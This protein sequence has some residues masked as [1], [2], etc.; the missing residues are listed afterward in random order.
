MPNP[1]KVT[2]DEVIQQLIAWKKNHPGDIPKRKHLPPHIRRGAKNRFGSWTNALHVAGF[3]VEPRQY[4]GIWQLEVIREALLIV[5]NEIGHSPTQNEFK[6]FYP[7]DAI[8]VAKLHYGGFNSVKESVGLPVYPQHGPRDWGWNNWHLSITAKILD[9]LDSNG[10]TSRGDFKKNGD[11]THNQLCTIGNLVRDGRVINA[12]PPYLHLYHLPGQEDSL[13]EEYRIF[14]V[15]QD[16]SGLTTISDK[17]RLFLHQNPSTFYEINYGLDLNQS[18]LSII[19]RLVNEDDNILKIGPR[20]H[21]LYYKRGQEKWLWP[22]LDSNHDIYKEEKILI[23]K[24][25]KRAPV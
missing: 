3:D 20:G 9:Y 6:D 13:P 5:A 25:L 2:H 16:T 23:A 21:C 15:D 12:G 24:Q 1:M 8:I 10:P 18:G 4:S 11:F 17:I 7:E 14:L 22:K 19:T